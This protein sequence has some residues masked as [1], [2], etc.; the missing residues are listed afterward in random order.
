MSKLTIA[1]IAKLPTN[2]IFEGLSDS[3]KETGQLEDVDR[4]IRLLMHSDHKHATVKG[5]TRCKRCMAKVD[6][7]RELLSSI[8]FSSYPQY[9]EWKRVLG[10]MINKQDLHFER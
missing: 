6:R 4:Q 9:L 5:F 3:L 2:P 1:E 8:G 10:V 7:R